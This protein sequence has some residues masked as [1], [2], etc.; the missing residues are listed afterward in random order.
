MRQLPA[1]DCKAYQDLPGN[2]AL[3]DKNMPQQ[4]F[5]GLLVIDGDAILVYIIQNGVL[6]LVGNFRQDQAAAA[7]HNAVGACPIEAGVGSAFFGGDG[8]LG[9]VAVAVAGGG[10]EDGQ[11]RQIFAADAV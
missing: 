11:L 7:F 6:D 4:P 10:G 3:T 5:S 2:L 1:V 8:V 9:F